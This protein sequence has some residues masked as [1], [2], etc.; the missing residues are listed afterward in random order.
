MSETPMVDAENVNAILPPGVSVTQDTVDAIASSIQNECGWHIA[1]IK[2][3]TVTLD[4][5]GGTVLQLPTLHMTGLTSVTLTETGEALPVSLETGW[6]EAGM[7]SLGPRSFIPGG[8]WASSR[9]SHKQFPAGFRA[10]TVSFT[11]GYETCPAELIR[12]I[13]MTVNQRRIVSETL[14][15]RAVTFQV[16][17]DYF[18]NAAILNK[19]RLGPR[20]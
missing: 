13:A 10:I 9:R 2:A 14:V 20:P 19:Y 3:E 6:S 8:H 7:L 15:G 12:F 16:T 17:D 18:S 4:S 5:D 11:H 1:P